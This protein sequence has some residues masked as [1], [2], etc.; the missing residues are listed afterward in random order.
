MFGQNKNEHN[1]VFVNRV[2]ERNEKLGL[3]ACDILAHA[4]DAV[5]PYKCVFNLVHLEADRVVIGS[6]AFSLKNF[7]RVFLIGFGK[8]AVPMAKALIDK[9]GQ[10]I[11]SASVITKDPGFLSEDGY[12]DML[13]VH[14]GG[15]PVPTEDSIKSTQAMLNSLPDLTE[16]DLVLVV[17][18]GGGSALFTDPV[19]GVTLQDMQS[20]TQLLLHS[21]ANIDEINTIRK[22]LD[23]VKGG[24]LAEILRPAHVETLILS[25]VIGDRLEIIASGPTVADTSTFQD[26]LEILDRYGVM[27]KVPLGALDYLEK[28]RDGEFAETMKPG[29][30]SPEQVDHHL[31]GTNFLAAQAAFQKAESMGYHTVIISTAVTGL[32]EQVAKFI[33]G[34]LTTALANDHPVAKPACIILGGEPTVNVTGTGL[35]GRNMDLTLRLVPGLAEKEGVLFISLATDGEDGPTD[36]AGAAADSYVLREGQQKFGL[37]IESFT[38]NND[39]YHYHEKVGALIKTGATGTNVNDLMLLLIDE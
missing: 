1:R 34:I 4:L 2:I 13:K 12:Q 30:L 6:K 7:E 29:L 25:D 20:L 27:G 5:H 15:H 9:L 32:T 11:S 39:A 35:G 21:G 38:A 14:L 23:Q 31:V 26:A 19:P 17:I 10:K 22:H 36:A 37:E 3:D 33:E 16:T 8:A 18:S 28:G 24:R